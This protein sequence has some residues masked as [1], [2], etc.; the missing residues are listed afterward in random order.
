MKSKL[1]KGLALAMAV[2]L[3]FGMLPSVTAQAAG[4]KKTLPKEVIYL[5]SSSGTNT[6]SF[7][8]D[9]ITTLSKLKS[10]NKDVKPIG[11]S[12]VYD[13][14]Q[15][16]IFDKNGKLVPSGNKSGYD[17]VTVNLQVSKKAKA[18]ITFTSGKVNYTKTIEVRKYTNP[19]K[20]LTVKN[21]KENLAGK[22]DKKCFLQGNEGISL[23]KGGNIKV[24]AEAANGWEITDIIFMAFD[25]E[26]NGNIYQTT[27][28]YMNGTE[29]GKAVL[30]D[31]NV[32]D[33]GYIRVN[34]RNKST[35]GTAFVY[36][37]IIGAKD[38]T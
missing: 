26:N 1:F 7:E 13:S 25:S 4:K 3:S 11:Y 12:A 21:V 10:S 24:T 29:K 20:S 35:G 32:K 8:V 23:S 28:I 33:N 31:Y 2:V 30:G 37:N 34:L 22:F 17:S 27:N 9:D 6:V 15:A 18:N 19:I 38:N 5:T 14:Y 36:T 16:Y